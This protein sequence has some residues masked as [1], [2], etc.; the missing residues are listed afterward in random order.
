MYVRTALFR[1]W[2]LT[3]TGSGCPRAAG[4]GPGRRQTHTHLNI[5]TH[6]HFIK[7]DYSTIHTYTSAA[8]FTATYIHT[9]NNNHKSWPAGWKTTARIFLKCTMGLLSLWV[10]EDSTYIH[11]YILISI[12][13]SVT[14]IKGHFQ[15]PVDGGFRQSLLLFHFHISNYEKKVDQ[16]VRIWN[17]YIHTYIHTNWLTQVFILFV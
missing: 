1:L 12:A 5:N 13:A 9:Y 17:T 16:Q 3:C 8:V 15:L 2:W 14:R 7:M 10:G 11:T 4:A 6:T